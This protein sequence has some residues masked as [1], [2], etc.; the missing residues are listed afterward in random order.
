LIRNP[1]RTGNR[2]ARDPLAFV[3]LPRNPPA[4]RQ[5]CWRSRAFLAL[6][7]SKLAN[8]TI[9]RLACALPYLAH[10]KLGL[11]AGG[12][13]LL[14]RATLSLTFCRSCLSPTTRL[15]RQF[16]FTLGTSEIARS[17]RG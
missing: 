3:C 16:A 11:S 7:E 2:R 8:R 6:T 15:Q 1:S 13:R 14:S 10:P 17:A 9:G 4:F 5:R 12:L